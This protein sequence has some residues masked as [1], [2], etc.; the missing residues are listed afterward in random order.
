VLDTNTVNG[1]T[2]ETGT[3]LTWVCVDFNKY[4]KEIFRIYRVDGNTVYFDQRGTPTGK[5]QHNSGAKVQINEI[6]EFINYLSANVDDFGFVEKGTTAG[7]VNVR[8]GVYLWNATQYARDDVVLTCTLA[9]G[10]VYFNPSTSVIAYGAS[11][12]SGSY[13]LARITCSAGVVTNIL[14]QRA[15]IFGSSSG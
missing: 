9:D 6:A 5:F 3:Y 11:V 7:T 10:Y 13:S 12:P 15:F 14:D 4:S 2:L 1:F 8:G